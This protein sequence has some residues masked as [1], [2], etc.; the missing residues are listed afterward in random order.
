MADRTDA[1]KP[2]E[3]EGVSIEEARLAKSA[4]Q[5]DGLLGPLEDHLL[6]IGLTRLGDGYALK[7]NLDSETP[8]VAGRPPEKLAGV[9]V[10]WD[11]V[12]RI[13]ALA[14]CEGLRHMPSKV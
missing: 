6:G 13:R 3:G 14:A 9:P 4:V 11:I 7:V 5:R 2:P 8:A 1:P 10:I 12:G